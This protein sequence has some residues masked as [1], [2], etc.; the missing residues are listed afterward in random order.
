MDDMNVT[1]DTAT[2]QINAA[3]VAVLR[4][5]IAVQRLDQGQIADSIGMARGSVNR[6]LNGHRDVPLTL[7]FAVAEAA[8]VAVSDLVERI[9]RELAEP[10]S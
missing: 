5:V 7:V 2:A 9:G 6:Y 4:S 1:T 8:G 3:T 10:L